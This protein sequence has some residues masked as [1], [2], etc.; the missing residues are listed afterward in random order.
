MHKSTQTNVSFMHSFRWKHLATKI[1]NLSFLITVSASK[2]SASVLGS[3]EKD[4]DENKGQD[5]N[6]ILSSA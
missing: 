2:D 4:S 5:K 1:W 3:I 6:G